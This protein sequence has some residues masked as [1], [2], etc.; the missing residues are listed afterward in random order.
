[1]S[2]VSRKDGR[3][4]DTIKF[5]NGNTKIVITG[6]GMETLIDPASPADSIERSFDVRVLD[7][8]QLDMIRANVKTWLDT[9]G[10]PQLTGLLDGMSLARATLIPLAK[11]QLRTRIETR[12]VTSKTEV[13]R[14]G[15]AYQRRTFK[16]DSFFI[17]SYVLGEGIGNLRPGE[18]PPAITQKA[19]SSDLVTDCAACR[20]AGSTRC[21]KCEGQGHCQCRSCHGDLEIG[22]TACGGKGEKKCWTC[23]GYGEKKCYSCLSGTLHDGRRCTACH[24]RGFTRC[25]ECRD[26]FKSCG[27]CARRG[28]IRCPSCDAA[29][30]VRCDSCGGIGKI[31]CAPCKGSGKFITSLYLTAKQSENVAHAWVLPPEYDA[32]VPEDVSAWLRQDVGITAARELSAKQFDAAPCERVDSLLPD[33]ANRLLDESKRNIRYRASVDLAALSDSSVDQIVRHWYAEYHLPLVKVDYQ[34]EGKD[35]TLWTVAPG[36]TLAD[37]AQGFA[38]K[39]TSVFASEGPVSAYLG[40]ML[41]AAASALGNGKLAESGHLAEALLKVVP[42]LKKAASLKARILWTQRLFASLGS[43]LAAAGASA[44]YVARLQFNVPAPLSDGAIA[45]LVIGVLAAVAPFAVSRIIYKTKAIAV[46]SQCALVS[47]MFLPVVATLGPA[48]PRA[49]SHLVPVAAPVSVI[50]SKAAAQGPPPAAAKPAP[51]LLPVHTDDTGAKPE[52]RVLLPPAAEMALEDQAPAAPVIAAGFDC[53]KASTVVEK[54]ICADQRLS[55]LDGKLAQLY[56]SALA[57]AEDPDA[58]RGEQRAWLQKA[59]NRC[60]DQ[61]CLAQ[62]YESQIAKFRGGQ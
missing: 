29:G 42:G 24:G 57:G 48:A 37:H 49:V 51:A 2:S 23:N 8:A 55:A 13:F 45:G 43:L 3:N 19:T 50:A 32:L 52:L 56:A 28:I 31:A 16:D 40:R 20:A 30:R 5:L 33:A 4:Q 15:A 21:G 36:V 11:V 38:T 46:F 18:L 34:F 17:W 26:G 14:N 25:N 35:Y 60:R 44:F 62:A 61:E 6:N 54:M 7:A 10:I 47:A 1:M 58:L 27:T 9:F 22:C 41:D 59:R 12:S 39:G 53:G